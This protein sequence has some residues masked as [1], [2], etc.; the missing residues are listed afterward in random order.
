[1]NCI[2]ALSDIY[3]NIY[4]DLDSAFYI[5]NKIN[6]KSLKNNYSKIKARQSNILISKGYLDSALKIISTN[7]YNNDNFTLDNKIKF[8]NV[9]ILLYKGNYNI[10]NQNLDSLLMK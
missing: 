9:E 5:L 10:F 3:L 4:S 7:K 8:K 2:L 1:M 6:N